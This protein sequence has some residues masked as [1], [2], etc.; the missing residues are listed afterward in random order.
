M[1]INRVDAG[2]QLA[3]KL[4]GYKNI[5]NGLVLAIPRGG[6]ETGYVIAGKLKLPLDVLVV[7]KIGAPENEELAIGAV[8]PPRGKNP[9]CVVVWDKDLCLRLGVDEA[10]KR[11]I[12]IEKEKEVVQRISKF[13]G[14]KKT[15]NVKGKII[16][17]VD[18]GIATGA[19]VEAAIVW[20]KAMSAKQIILAVP[21]AAQD[22]W[23]KLAGLVDE[24]IALET[25]GDFAAVGQFYDNFQP[26]TD[27]RVKELLNPAEHINN[28][29]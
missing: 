28:Q 9:K 19:T 27:E 26:V 13:R 6:V 1:F 25:P 7:R 12:E 18:D 8:G 23:G 22:T 15:L 10:W 2:R 29:G 14:E 4:L 17:L 21:V 16:I 24:A 20:L 11:E 3:E 5:K